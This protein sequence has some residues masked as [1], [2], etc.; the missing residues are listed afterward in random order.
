MSTGDTVVLDGVSVVSDGLVLIIDHQGRRFGLPASEIRAGTTVRNPGD[1][2][3]LVISR[4][5]AN[6]I[7]LP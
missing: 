3:R 7:G 6:R 2:G 5:W 1:H 4:D